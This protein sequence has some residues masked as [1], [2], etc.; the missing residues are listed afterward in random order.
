MLQFHQIQHRRAGE[1]QWKQNKFIGLR[2]L[3][4]KWK[5]LSAENLI[6]FYDIDTPASLL[7]QPIPGEIQENWSWVGEERAFN[8]NSHKNFQQIVFRVPFNLN[9]SFI[10]SSREM[11]SLFPEFC[12]NSSPCVAKWAEIGD[13]KQRNK[14]EYWFSSA[15]INWCKR[16][17]SAECNKMSEIITSGINAANFNYEKSTRSHVT[18]RCFAQTSQ[19]AVKSTVSRTGCEL[20]VASLEHK[21]CFCSNDLVSRKWKELKSE[22]P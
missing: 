7:C 2:K 18:Q 13:G 1:S 4:G 12:I 9:F 17:M 8:S 19:M 14:V 3:N 15:T 21:M 16:A 6:L 5:N 11:F 22:K 20:I 10:I